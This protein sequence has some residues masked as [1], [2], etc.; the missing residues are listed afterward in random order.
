MVVRRSGPEGVGAVPVPRPIKIV[1]L[2]LGPITESRFKVTK[3]YNQTIF[4]ITITA[5]NALLQYN[6]HT[7]YAVALIVKS[8]YQTHRHRRKCSLELYNLLC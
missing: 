6:A 3:F 7:S 2:V 1:C 4:T 8:D 5:Y